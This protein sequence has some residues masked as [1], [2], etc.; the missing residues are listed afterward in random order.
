MQI[1]EEYEPDSGSIAWG[2]EYGALDASPLIPAGS[3][4][5]QC[6]GQRG[7]GRPRTAARERME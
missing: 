6:V 3:T 4:K 1:R 7:F 5:E 2:Y